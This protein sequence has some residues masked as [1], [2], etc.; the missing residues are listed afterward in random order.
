MRQDILM[1]HRVQLDKD[2]QKMPGT[3]YGE[4]V[5]LIHEKNQMT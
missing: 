2:T 1:I 5:W 3:Q 4:I